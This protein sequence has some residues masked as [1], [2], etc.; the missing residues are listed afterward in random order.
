VP[1]LILSDIHG[2]LEA[3]DAVLADAGG[4]YDRILCLGDLVGYGADPNAIVAWARGNV[5]TIVRG[6]HDRVCIGLEPVDTYNPAAQASALW[7]QSELTP[8]H[9][10]YLESLP[11]GPLFYEGVDLVHGSP[12]DEDEYLLSIYQLP[13]LH[14][15]L[16]SQVT[17]FGHT[18]V[19]GGFLMA[20]RGSGL[21]PPNLALSIQSDYFYLVNPGS[22]GQPRDGDPRAAYAL[23]SPEEHVVEFHRVAY[24]IDRAAAKIRAAG[25]PEFLAARL[26]EGV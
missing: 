1:Y 19:Q 2:N 5:R 10:D 8:A 4:C 22:V 14:P 12:A 16:E 24:D 3:L 11:R 15:F 26:H 20:P 6:N 21:L 25:L 9:R 18:H 7:T 23:Y 17:F 13:A